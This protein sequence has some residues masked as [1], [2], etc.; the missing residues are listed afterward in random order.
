MSQTFLGRTQEIDKF[1]EVIDCLVNTEGSSQTDIKP[2]I[3][4]YSGVAGIGKTDL[5]DKLK[6]VA[7]T[8][9]AGNLNTISF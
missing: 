2:Y 3:F 1:T 6:E 5:L 4:L 8:K 9:L 7:E